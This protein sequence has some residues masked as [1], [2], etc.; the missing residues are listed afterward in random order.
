[1]ITLV[2][3]S[4]GR[5]FTRSTAATCVS[6]GI[7]HAYRLNVFNKIMYI[8]HCIRCYTLC[9]GSVETVFLVKHGIVCIGCVQLGEKDVRTEK[10]ERLEQSTSHL[11]MLN[12][13]EW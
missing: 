2:C 3:A 7:F 10:A 1:M 5:T 9:F 4:C 8:V 13:K 12:R 11:E 6:H